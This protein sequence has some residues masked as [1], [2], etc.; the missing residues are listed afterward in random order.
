[1]VPP[2]PTPTLVH[3]IDKKR[4]TEGAIELRGMKIR[5]VARA[6]CSI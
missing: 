6:L 5:R 1:M 3:D 2:G 4:S